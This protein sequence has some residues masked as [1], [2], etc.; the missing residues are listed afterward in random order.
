MVGAAKAGTTWLYHCF[1]EHPDIFVSTPKELHFF[2]R[3]G[4]YA[5]GY[6]WYYSFFKEQN[7]S[8]TAVGEVCPSYH[9]APEVPQRI[10]Q[11]N[12]NS[13]LIFIIRNPIKRAYS[14][15]CMK[16]DHGTASQNIS[17]ELSLS[18]HYVQRSL[19]YQQVRGYLDYF[20]QDQFKILVFDDLKKNPQDFI[21]D[22]YNFLGV[23]QDFT[24]ATLY[25]SENARKPPPRHMNIYGPLRSAYMSLVHRNPEVEVFVH[26]LKRQGHLNFF[27][28]L[29]RGGEYPKLTAE[30]QRTLADF[31]HE[32]VM[33]LSNLLNRDL[34]HWL[35][36]S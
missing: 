35:E 2:S 28:T 33:Q 31:F 3:D 1:K 19:Y 12:P 13:K 24:P 34:S 14:A 7:T 22:A 9:Y 6:D 20:P 27:Y 23:N 11:W 16:V 30:A 10:Y 29:M 4:N 8:Q 21:K 25:R 26:K 17:Q 18:S 5:R 36:P 32:D 15:Y